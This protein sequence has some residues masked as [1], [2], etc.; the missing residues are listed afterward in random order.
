MI[1]L[2][3]L[4]LVG[5]ALA[6]AMAITLTVW[7]LTHP[8]RRTYA[9]AVARGRPGDPSELPT[10]RAFQ[11]WTLQSR[12]NSIP[13]WDLPGDAPTGP[14][15]IMLHGWGDSKLGS[16]SR[17]SAFLPLASRVLAIDLPGHGEASGCSRLG[18]DEHL[19]VLS[20]IDHLK[21]ETPGTGIVLFGWSLGAGIAIA[22]AA[23]HLPHVRGVIAEAPYIH[24]AT[25]AARVL[26]SRNLPAGAILQAALAIIGW[27]SSPGWRGFDR[28]RLA[29]SLRVPLLVIHGEADEISPIQDGR[30]IAQAALFGSLA[31]IPTAGHLGLWSGDGAESA[32]RSLATWWQASALDR[33]PPAPPAGF[34]CNT[35]AMLPS[36][37]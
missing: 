29:A 22:A 35:G 5:M 37:P 23:T 20:L 11:S 8:P 26:M 10:P 36:P 16:L 1:G 13:I 25:P 28:A 12:G 30:T 15:V 19:D 31:T 17:L 2:A 33:L 14:I 34:P 24:P 32:R 21:A 3:G 27:I 9:S 6:I 7:R 4:L 18:I